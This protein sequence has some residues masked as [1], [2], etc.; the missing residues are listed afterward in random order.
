MSISPTVFGGSNERGFTLLEIMLAVSLL[1]LVST[2]TM[3][4]LGAVVTAWQRGLSLSERLHHGDF[5]M[6][7]LVA[8]LGSIYHTAPE[9]G[10]YLED[11]GV[12]E[13]SSDVIRWVKIGDSLTGPM[14]GLHRVEFWMENREDGMVVSVRAWDLLKENTDFDPLTIEPTALSRP[15]TITGFNCRTGQRDSED[16]HKIEWLDEWEDTNSVPEF[17]E[18]TLYL[19][20]MDGGRM[21]IESKRIVETRPRTT[22]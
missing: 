2:I 3:L 8:G 10:F 4:A 17:V 18:I 16:A 5:V 22:L 15:D 19:K 6:Q 13:R 21:P 7:Q 12:G 14:G 1:A 11:N 9:H 20:P